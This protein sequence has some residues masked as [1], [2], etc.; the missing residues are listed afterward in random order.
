MGPVNP[1]KSSNNNILRCTCGR[2]RSLNLP[3]SNF[4]FKVMLIC[5]ITVVAIAICGACTF[6]VTDHDCD[7]GCGGDDVDGGDGGDDDR[8][9]DV[10][11]YEKAAAATEAR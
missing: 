9:E 7:C 3:T 4:L 5:I 8:E 1:S 2:I 6:S 11:T 10:N